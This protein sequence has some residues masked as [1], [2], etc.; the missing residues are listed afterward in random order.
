[1]LLFRT[2]AV[3]L[4]LVPFSLL[5]IA[6]QLRPA[7][8]GLGTHQQLGLPPCTMRVILGIRCPSCGMTTSWSYFARG[9]LLD[10]LATNSGGCLLAIFSLAFAAISV[11]AAIGGEFPG[12]VAQKWLGVSLLAIAAVTLV[13]WAVRL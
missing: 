8:A 7:A 11:R 12:Y 9:Q 1:M 6:G 13:D 5:G 10:S 3:I 4:S 2:I